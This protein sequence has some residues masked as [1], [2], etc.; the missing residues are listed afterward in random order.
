MAKQD[1]LNRLRDKINKEYEK[2]GM[3][4]P[5]Q[6]PEPIAHHSTGLPSLDRILGGGWAKGKIIEL[7]SPPGVGKT[8]LALQTIANCQTKDENCLFIDVERAFNS[9]YAKALGVD[10]DKLIYVKPEYGEQS[11]DIA[12]QY[13]ETGELS[14][15]VLDSVASLLPKDTSERT[16]EQ[17]EQATLARLLSRNIPKF[18]PLLDNTGTTFIFINQIRKDVGKM[19]GN[20][21]VTPGGETLKFGSFI[22]LE[23]RQTEIIKNGDEKIGAMIK[24]LSRKSKS[25]QPFQETMLRMEYGK[26]FNKGYDTL[27]LAL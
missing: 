27:Q 19:F 10:L 17:K 8:T 3:P 24:A 15:V 22:R 18:I 25:S 2:R 23:L 16:M 13:V 12:H 1:K 26:G 4:A 6:D 14:L 11:L 21:E 5:V 7:W 20:P 9:D